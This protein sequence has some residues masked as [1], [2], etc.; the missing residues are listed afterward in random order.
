MSEQTTRIRLLFADEGAFHTQGLT[1][2]L[3]V[4]EDYDRLIDGL[5]EDPEVLKMIHLDISR[6][7]AAWVEGAE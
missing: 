7:A 3:S 5:R 6:L 1:V 2:P 4:V